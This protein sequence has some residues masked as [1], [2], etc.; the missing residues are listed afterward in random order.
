MGCN[1][2][3]ELT[4]VLHNLCPIFSL[5]KWAFASSIAQAQHLSISSL[6]WI[7]SLTEKTKISLP[8]A[9]SKGWVQ[10]CEG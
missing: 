10:Q 5:S 4:E 7:L 6:S 1:L 3:C 9:L 8:T 2:L